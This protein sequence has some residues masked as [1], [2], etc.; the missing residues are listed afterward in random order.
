MITN[1][2]QLNA[3]IG[4]LVNQFGLHD[5]IFGRGPDINILKVEPKEYEDRYLGETIISSEEDYFQIF[6]NTGV[7]VTEAV[8]NT[9][10]DSR[11]PTANYVGNHG[12]EFLQHTVNTIKNRFAIIDSRRGEFWNYPIIDVLGGTHRLLSD[13]CTIVV[14]KNSFGVPVSLDRASRLDFYKTDSTGNNDSDPQLCKMIAKYG[15]VYQPAG[16]YHKLEDLKNH[17]K[18]ISKV[19]YYKSMGKPVDY[20]VTATQRSTAAL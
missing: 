4:E 9:V 19:V 7:G 20:V 13:Q 8:C 3:W 14:P 2:L 12:A 18:L 15:M 10:Y 6:I 11:R 1:Q 17:P 5:D 16:C